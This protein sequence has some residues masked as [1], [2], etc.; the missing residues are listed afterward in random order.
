MSKLLPRSGVLQV[1]ADSLE[2]LHELLWDFLDKSRT[3]DARFTGE[4]QAH[5]MAPEGPEE[6]LLRKR[7]EADKIAKQLADIDTYIKNETLR[8]KRLLRE[9]DN[10]NKA[11]AFRTLRNNHGR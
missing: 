3:D 9:I 7:Q 10:E 4:L 8:H 2:E 6:A 5:W 1:S 11:Y